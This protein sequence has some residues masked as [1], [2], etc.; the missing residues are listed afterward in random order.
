MVS[1]LEAD[2]TSLRVGV[3]DTVSKS[4]GHSHSNSDSG[5]VVAAA[6]AEAQVAHDLPL[7]QQSSRR[8]AQAAEATAA[9]EFTKYFL[10][11][12]GRQVDEY[13][14]QYKLKLHKA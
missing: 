4:G 3:G 11:T 8:S 7:L 9:A 5:R 13:I 6:A 2:S 10:V 1:A 12:L 14:A